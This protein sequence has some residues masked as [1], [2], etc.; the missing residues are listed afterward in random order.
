[1]NQVVKADE[2]FRFGQDV[3]CETILVRP[4]NLIVDCFGSASLGSVLFRWR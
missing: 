3:D 1:M 4:T 2:A